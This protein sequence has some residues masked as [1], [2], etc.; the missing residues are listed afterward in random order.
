M[1]SVALKFVAFVLC[2]CFLVFAAGSLVGIGVLGFAGL[3]DNSPEE[4]YQESLERQGQYIAQNVLAVYASEAL[5][6]CPESMITMLYGDIHSNAQGQWNAVIRQKNETLW[7]VTGAPEASHR[8][9]YNLTTRYFSMTPPENEW[10]AYDAQTMPLQEDGEWVEY[11][12]YSYE[13]PAYTVIVQLSPY[14]GMEDKWQILEVL[15]ADRYRLIVLASVSLLLF[16]ACLVYLCWAAGRSTDSTERRPGGLNRLPL[17]VYTGILAGM[18]FLVIFLGVELIE[19]LYADAMEQSV[20]IVGSMLAAVLSLLVVGFLFALSAQLK[21]KGGYWWR[22]SLIG[23][24][25]LLLY[26]GIRRCL[27]WIYRMICLIP[28]VWRLALIGSG[29]GFFLFIVLT[30]AHQ[31]S[32]ILWDLGIA[33]IPFSYLILLGYLCYAYGTLLKGVRRMKQG[34]LS[35][36]ID[37]RFLFGSFREFARGLNAISDAAAIAAEKQLRSERMKTELITNVSHDIKT[38]LT[39][40]I[41]YVDLLQKPHGEQEQAQYL[42]VLSRQSGRLKKLVEDLM[43]MSK[44]STGNI[45][46]VIMP[47][48]AVEAV[49]QA[50]GEFSEK[51]TAASL[52]PVL[53]V[54]EEPVS[55]L[56]D[57]RLVW[58]VL[59]NLLSNA[60]KYALPG[61]RLYISVCRHKQHVIISIKNISR[62]QLGI[63]AEELMERFVRGDASRNTEGSGLG[64][65]IAKSLMEL[66]KGQ[67]KLLVDGDLFKVTL[68]FPEADTKRS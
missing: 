18:G 54:P 10:D 30:I 21:T 13:T 55:M 51:L 36:K 23:R 38:P 28:V 34:T 7:S 27:G 41:N 47:L 22:N 5:G 60:V 61:T 58:R 53:D 24:L 9:E 43:E 48:D 17:D 35:H 59:S 39:S 4:L 37:T 8:L 12:I 1:K 65:N 46:T 66:Q 33:V 31:T 42:E 52:I 68:V 20:L 29:I 64:L 15:Y 32:D 50:L 67:L 25:L 2:S 56:A 14:Q 62:E 40:I 11:T 45:R 19:E 44:A 63:R 6:K 57:S 49:N 3:Y 16:A 26:K